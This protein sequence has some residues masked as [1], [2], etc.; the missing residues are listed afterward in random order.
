[1]IKIKKIF[2]IIFISVITIEKANSEIS[3]SLFASVGNKAI[4]NSDI[5]NELKLLLI[6][7]KQLKEY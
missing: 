3:D 2:L 6:L 7:S 5:V 1:M 4:T